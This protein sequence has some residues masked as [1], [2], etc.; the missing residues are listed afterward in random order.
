MIALD[1]LCGAVPLEMVPTI[2]KKDTT[3]ELCDA[4][5][6]MRIHDNRMKKAM[7]QQV[8]WKFDL[9]TFDDGET[10]EEY[11]RRLSGMAADLDMLG[12]V[13]KDGKIIVKMLRYRPP[14]FKHITIVI[15]RLLIVST[16][17]VADLIRWL[18]EVGET[19]REAPTSLQQDRNLYLTDE[20]WDAQR[21]K[22]EAEN[23]SGAVQAKVVGVVALHRAG[24]SNKPTNNECRHC[25]K[26]GH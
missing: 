8:H 11:T 16:M 3:K 9:T 23:H 22:R 2:V 1:A 6:T 20:E 7:M 17:S 10:I 14:H 25:G 24:S 26:M 15:K 13:V 12:E 21:K 19:F 5:M 4:I 18:K